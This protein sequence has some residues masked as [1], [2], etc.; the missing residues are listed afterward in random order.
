M[1]KVYI[2]SVVVGKDE[3]QPPP[4]KVYADSA[5]EAAKTWGRW[6]LLP[7][8]GEVTVAVRLGESA[9]VP[10]YFTVNRPPIDKSRLPTVRPK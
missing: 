5:R 1:K 7:E 4:R 6:N 2:V 8:R 9:F 10:E 3:T